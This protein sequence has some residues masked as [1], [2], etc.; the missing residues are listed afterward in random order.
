MQ[1]S[2]SISVPLT[3]MRHHRCGKTTL[4]RL[5]AKHTDAVFKE[6]SATDSG[7]SDIRAVAGE[8]KNVLKLS[9]RY[10]TRL[11][12]SLA[13]RLTYKRFRRTILFLDEVH[14]FNKAQQVSLLMSH[15]HTHVTDTDA[16]QDIF[17]PFVE[18][19]VI[20][21]RDIISGQRPG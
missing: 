5:L 11:C 21:V 6:L 1:L 15:A 7:I 16:T 14:R 4:A 13:C 20:Q 12:N 9:G 3:F 17:L 18:Q 2:T 10:F 8:A 19:G